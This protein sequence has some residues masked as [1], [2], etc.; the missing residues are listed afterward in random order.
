MKGASDGGVDLSFRLKNAG[1]QM[2]DEVPQLYLGA[3]RKAP[4]GA[5]FAVRA[6]A[7]FDRIA[8]QPGETST[9]TLHVARRSLEYW[10]ISAGRWMT[11]TGPRTVYV[12]ASSR[13]L[14]LQTD[15]VIAP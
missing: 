3:P 15:A 7:G 9:V 1:K 13:D 4:D 14:R 5:Q 6:L 2:S 11:A 8:V 10:S 12:G